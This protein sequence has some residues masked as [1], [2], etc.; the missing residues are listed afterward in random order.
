MEYQM[1]HNACSVELNGGTKVLVRL[2]FKGGRDPK[3]HFKV[4][5]EDGKYCFTSESFSSSTLV[6]NAIL[7]FLNVVEGLFF[8]GSPTSAFDRLVDLF[9]DVIFED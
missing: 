5:S 6:I 1:S 8:R 7:E 2:F 9:S 3:W 4:M